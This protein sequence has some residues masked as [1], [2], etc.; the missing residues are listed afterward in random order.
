MAAVLQGMLY[1]VREIRDRGRAPDFQLLGAMLYYLDAFPERF[2]HPKEDQYLFAL[3]RARAPAAAPVLDRLRAEHDSGA[4]RIRFL[5]QA[6]SRYEQGGSAEFAAFAAAVEGYA[7]FHWEHMRCEEKEVIPMAEKQLTAGD[8]QTIDAVFAGHTDP[9]FGVVADEAYHK[10]FQRIL[11]LA[12]P[13]IGVG[14]VR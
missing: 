2:H 6:L 5:Q 11:N 10:L 13:P 9:L 3:L 12:P 1:I 14:P 7:A 4:E 8:W